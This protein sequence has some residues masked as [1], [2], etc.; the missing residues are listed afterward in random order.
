MSATTFAYVSDERDLAI[1]GADLEV[2]AQ[3]GSVHL[4]RSSPSGAVHADLPDGAYDIVVSAAG[5]G[6]KRTSIEV[7]RDRE[8]TRIRLLTGAPYGYAWPKCAAAG[9]TVELRL[10]SGEPFELTLWRYGWEPE[11]VAHVGDFDDHPPGANLQLLPDGDV[12]ALGCSWNELGFVAPPHPRWTVVAPQ[13]SGLYWFHLT[14]LSGVFTSFPLVVSPAEPTAP[15]A[16]LASDITWCAYND[17]GGRSNYIAPARLP[18]APAVNTRQEGVWFP[19]PELGSW[20]HEHYDPLSF[21]RPEPHNR[22]GRDDRITDPI[23]RRGGEHVAPGEWRLLGW[24]EREGFAFDLYGETQFNRD[25]LSL[26]DYRVLVISTHPEYWTRSMYEKLKAW[27]TERG[28]RLVYLGGNGINCEVTFLDDRTMRVEN[29]VHSELRQAAGDREDGAWT[30][31]FE[32]DVES[33]ATLLGVRHTWAG[34]ETGAPYEVV[35]PDHWVFAGTGLVAGDLFGTENLNARCHPGG[36]SGHETDKL[37]PAS[38]PGTTLLARGV[39]ADGGGAHLVHV[40][41]ASGG[42][43]FSAGSISYPT[44]LSVDAAL[45]RVTA[46]VLNR[47]LS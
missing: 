31:R 23:T 14:T 22:I 17:F 2:T 21:D 40:E 13:R 8:P 35:E 29:G 25:E 41:H 30:T 47:F 26:E 20:E 32:R 37:G 7:R 9:S 10:H 18:A 34:F 15:M 1:P 38:P 33:E 4:L 27:V 46:N 44:S 42:Q 5:H 6:A 12:A 43:V 16:V 45:S 39:N 3:D 28:G 19:D 36:A 11:M 24:L